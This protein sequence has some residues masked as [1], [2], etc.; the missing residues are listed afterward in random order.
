MNHSTKN[1]VSTKNTEFNN[2]DPK[3]MV[4]RL[5]VS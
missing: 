4:R 3:W 1:K 2:N 5:Y